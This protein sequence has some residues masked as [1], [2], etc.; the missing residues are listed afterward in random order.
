M[1]AQIPAFGNADRLSG[2]NNIVVLRRGIFGEYVIKASICEG[3]WWDELRR[4]GC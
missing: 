4:V 1:H 2:C 3:R